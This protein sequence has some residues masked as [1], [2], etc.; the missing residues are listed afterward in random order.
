MPRNINAKDLR[1][2][3][4]LGNIVITVSFCV[5]AYNLFAVRLLEG[6]LQMW[7]PTRV[8]HS[9]HTVHV[10]L[11]PVNRRHVDSRWHMPCDFRSTLSS[12]RSAIHHGMPLWFKPNK[13]IDEIPVLE[14]WG[15]T[16]VW[17]HSL[18]PPTRQVNTPPKLTPAS[19]LVL[20]LP[21]LEGWKA[22]LT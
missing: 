6:S 20:D 18:L 21:T 17:D 1:V 4:F 16:A 13:A 19:K 11:Q 8:S 14:L 3:R 5:L 7:Q 15:V 10:D 9:R 2:C 22:E 12:H